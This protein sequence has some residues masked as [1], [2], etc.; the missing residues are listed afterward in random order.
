M[1]IIVD[2]ELGL[3][4]VKNENFFKWGKEYTTT[5][6]VLHGCGSKLD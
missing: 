6:F 1:I 3:K 2:R 5:K 4:R